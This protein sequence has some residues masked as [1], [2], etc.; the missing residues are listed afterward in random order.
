[1]VVEISLPDT[2]PLLRLLSSL[3]TEEYVDALKKAGFTVVLLPE[4]DYDYETYINFLLQ[5]KADSDREC[6]YCIRH[7]KARISSALESQQA[8]IISRNAD[9]LPE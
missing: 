9:E 7:P 5:V 1:M 2:L 8:I 6:T 4:P 3:Q